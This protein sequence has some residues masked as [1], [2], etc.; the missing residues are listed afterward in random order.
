MKG[1]QAATFFAHWNSPEGREAVD[2]KVVF[3]P[4]QFNYLVG[5]ERYGACAWLQALV[6][7]GIDRYPEAMIFRAF[8]LPGV[9]L[10]ND[11]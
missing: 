4:V 6:E 2:L 9:Q 10:W 8:G 1:R 5:G 7:K 3:A 11:N